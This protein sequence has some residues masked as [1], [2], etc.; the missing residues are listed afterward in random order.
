MVLV[1]PAQRSSVPGTRERPVS[2]HTF[3]SITEIIDWV[4]SRDRPP[5]LG[6]RVI[7]D[8]LYSDHFYEL[9]V[10][11]DHRSFGIGTIIRMP[12]RPEKEKEEVWGFELEYSDEVDLAALEHFFEILRDSLPDEI[13]AN[14]R[15]VARSPKQTQLIARLRAEKHPLAEQLTSYAELAVPGEIE[16]YNPGLIAGRLRKL[17]SDPE[18]AAKLLTAGDPRAIWIMPVVPDEL[19]PAAGLLTATQQTPLAHV[20]LLARNRGIPNVYVGGVMDDPHFDQLSRIHA[21]V[22]VLAKLDG[23]LVIEPIGEAEYARWLGLSE[24]Q[25]PKLSPAD[26]TTLP[27]VIDLELEPPQRV[28]EL[29]RIVGGKT[30]G[31]VILHTAGVP[32]PERPLAI[33]TRAYHEHLA[34]LRPAIA[35]AL[36]DPAFTR[37]ARVRYLLLEGRKDFDKHFP[38]SSDQAWVEVFEDTHPATASKRDAL[39]NLLARDGIKKAIRERP[40]EANARAAIDAALRAH[41]GHFAP[42]QGLRFRSS[43]TVED[44][45]GFSGAGLYDSNT[46]FLDPTVLPD[47]KERDKSIDWALRRTW[48]SYWSWEAFE[49]RNLAK[50]DH[51]AGDMAVLVHARFDDERERSNAVLTLTLDISDARAG[52]MQGTAGPHASLEVDV[53]IGALSVTNPPPERAGEVLPEIDRVVLAHPNGPIRIERVARSTELESGYILDDAALETLLR[54][55]VTIAERWLEVENQGVP[56]AR[57]RSRVTLDLEVREVAAGWPAYASGDPAPQR[58]VIKQVRSLD[59]GLPRG[60]D[61]LVEQP[62]PRDLMMYADRIEKRTCRGRRAS[63]ELL[64]L[65]TDPGAMPPLGHANVPFLARVRLQAQGL[66][67]GPRQFDLDHLAF[68]SVDHPGMAAGAPWAMELVLDD[69]AASAVGLD[70]IESRAGLLR[71]SQ[72]GRVLAEDP[73][74]CTTEVLFASPDEFLRALLGSVEL[75]RDVR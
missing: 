51:L 2:G 18:R 57:A 42:T 13:A 60:L 23:T 4:R 27:Y 45:E 29:R 30:A 10:H 50:I 69:A 17:P 15:F 20:N 73:A 56:P 22:V 32:M 61:R 26:P 63:L 21:P 52:V 31:L 11:R 67:G 9:A 47:K 55:T 35:D 25:R 3:A 8:R 62:V 6:M 75:R 68:V 5:P 54:Q 16:V 19:P 64:E 28:P 71:L 1:S 74:P 24:Q 14:L 59:P 12:A 43:S 72:A 58:I 37:D 41:F 36:D 34:E 38:G 33:T 49:E 48:A 70:H 39:A 65:W 46:G 7:D 53:Q 40:I 44:V 66:D